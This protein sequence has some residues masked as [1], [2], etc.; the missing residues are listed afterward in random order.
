MSSLA[1]VHLR[2]L[3][4]V[5]I[6]EGEVVR[7]YVERQLLICEALGTTVKGGG[8]GTLYYINSFSHTLAASNARMAVSH[9]AS[10]ATI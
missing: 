8:K 6:Y 1:T 3:S 2:E 7:L 9:L 10:K 4:E 5:E